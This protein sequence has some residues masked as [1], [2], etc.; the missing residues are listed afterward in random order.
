MKKVTRRTFIKLGAGAAAACSFFPHMVF[1][2]ESRGP[3]IGVAHG[4]KEK[5]VK[6]AVDALGGIDTFVR[7]GDTVC[8]KPNISFAANIECGATTSP[9]VVKQ[10]VSLCLAAGAARVIILD[11]TIQNA[12][13]CREK[14]RIDEAVIDKKKVKVLT[15]TKKRQFGEVSI[16]G[17]SELQVVDV[18]KAIQSSDTLINVPTAKSH[19]ATGV[20][21]GIKNLMGLIWD[22]GLLHRLNLHRAIAELA[23]VI[24]PDLTIIDA[25]RALT[26]GGPGGPGKTVKLDMAI[27][28]RDIVAVDSYGVGITEWYDQAFTGNQVKYIVEAAGLGLGEIDTEKMHVVKVEV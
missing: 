26:T 18:A 7:S 14:S 10:V 2:E 9:G 16:P 25:T 11:K 28:G 4:D 23:L 6:A 22:R 15:L 24:K 17:G 19:S 5:L 21:L 20:S 13:L 12:E 8:I 3:T 27:A 1:G